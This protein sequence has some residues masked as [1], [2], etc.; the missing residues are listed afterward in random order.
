[1]AKERNLNISP[2]NEFFYRS[3]V[4]RILFPLIPLCDDAL[5]SIS[6][7]FYECLFLTQVLRA[8]FCSYILGVYFLAQEYRPVVP[9]L[10]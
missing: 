10:F 6:P 5:W 4:Q 3:S 7:K 1:M 9:K 2:Q 8:A